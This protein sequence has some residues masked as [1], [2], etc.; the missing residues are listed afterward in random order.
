M[1]KKKKD[2]NKSLTFVVIIMAVISVFIGFYV[3]MYLFKS[4]SG[5]ES[6]VAQTNNNISESN[7]EQSVSNNLE[8]EQINS[9]EQ[10]NTNVQSSDENTENN[11]INNVEET[12]QEQNYDNLF[13]IQVGAFSSRNNADNFKSELESKGYQVIIK[14]TETFR[15]RVL[16]KQTR[17]ET[18]QIEQELI[19]LGYDTFIVK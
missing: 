4:F 7:T 12:S 17:E 8:N 16:G 3:C 14:E 13:K 2:K 10:S 5:G 19:N 1:A 18:E 11:E 15:V 9:N 6:Q